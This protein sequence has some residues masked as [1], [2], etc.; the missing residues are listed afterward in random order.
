MKLTKGNVSRIL[1]K[2]GVSR[3]LIVR[4]RVRGGGGVTEGFSYIDY[5]QQPENILYI[6]YVRRT[7]SYGQASYEEYLLRKTE[8]IQKIVELLTEKGF[9]VENESGKIKVTL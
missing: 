4:G 8:K 5:Y 3:S 6:E 2:G 9:K 1:T 7:S